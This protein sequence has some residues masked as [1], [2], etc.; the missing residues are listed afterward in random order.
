MEP[1]TYEV[2]EEDSLVSISLKHNVSL[3]A[4][5][6]LNN[7]SEDSI[8][9]PGMVL[10]IEQSESFQTPSYPLIEAQQDLNKQRVFY[11]SHKGDIKGTLIYNEYA[12]N[13]IPDSINSFNTLIHTIDGINEVEAVDYFQYIDHRDV[14]SVS[15]VQ[16]PG[17]D[18]NQRADDQLYLKIIIKKTGFEPVDQ[19]KSTPKGTVYFKVQSI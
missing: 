18:M 1:F 12:L 13:F 5:L 11:C 4:L 14:L 7:L 3:Y 17:F 19:K 9:F 2:K 15:V 8:L 16:Y 6:R 10:K